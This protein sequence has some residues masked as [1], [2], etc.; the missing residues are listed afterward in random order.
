MYSQGGTEVEVE[1]DDDEE[2]DREE[3]TIRGAA[4]LK[5]REA[6]K[7]A[8]DPRNQFDGL[9]HK[10]GKRFDDE[11]LEVAGV[12]ARMQKQHKKHREGLNAEDIGQ[13]ESMNEA[14][15][16]QDEIQDAI[17]ESKIYQKKY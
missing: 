7:K 12:N 5:E 4:I 15:N 11:G 1:A 14:I 3:K 13:H 16:R 6:K 9:L 2:E 10:N 8:D 17:E